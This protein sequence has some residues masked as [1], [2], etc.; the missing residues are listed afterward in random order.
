MIR[1]VNK[2]DMVLYIDELDADSSEEPNMSPAIVTKVH[3][4]QSVHHAHQIVDLV[5]FVSNG[6]FFKYDVPFG[7]QRGHWFFKP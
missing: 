2:G 5:S 4:L 7:N 6:V 3:N 1:L